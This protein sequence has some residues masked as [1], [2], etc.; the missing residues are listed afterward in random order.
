M[1]EKTE[2]R[3][4]SHMV[5]VKETGPALKWDPEPAWASQADGPD[6]AEGKLVCYGMRLLLEHACPIAPA[7]DGD[8]PLPETE[9]GHFARLVGEGWMLTGRLVSKVLSIEAAAPNQ[10]YFVFALPFE[11]GNDPGSD[12]QNPTAVF[13]LEVPEQV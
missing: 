7:G 6:K 5:T 2:V 8:D 1:T 11:K 12:L 10:K 9:E 13:A 3:V 4:V